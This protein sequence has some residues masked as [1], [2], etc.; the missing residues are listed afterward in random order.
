[1]PDSRYHQMFDRLVS[2]VTA[3]H[4]ANQQRIHKGLWGMVV[5]LVLYL[6][7]LFVTQGSKVIIL[8]LWIMTMFALA[9]Y[10]IAVE[11]LNHELKKKLEHITQM[12]LDLGPT[13]ADVV[14]EANLAKLR[15]M[16][17]AT[18]SLVD[19]I[20][21]RL[22]SDAESSAIDGAAAVEEAADLVA[23]T[24]ELEA[25]QASTQDAETESTAAGTPDTD[26]AVSADNAPAEPAEAERA[27]GEEKSPDVRDERPADEAS[28]GAT[29]VHV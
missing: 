23:S 3:I 12:E 28:E 29:E 7:L 5:V 13:A 19:V 24:I 6:T 8:L 17:A 14:A 1:M 25:A 21:R 27:E 16:I 11:Y 22:E 15:G 2:E 18:P 10:L 26:S 4:Q 20:L 9:A